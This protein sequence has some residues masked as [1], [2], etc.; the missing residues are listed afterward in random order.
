MKT[1][2]ILLQS[3]SLSSSIIDGVETYTINLIDESLQT[4]SIDGS[5]IKWL[6]GYEHPSTGISS[7]EGLLLEI[8]PSDISDILDNNGNCF[9]EAIV[10][11]IITIPIEDTKEVDTTPINNPEEAIAKDTTTVTKQ[12]N[13]RYLD[14]YCI[15]HK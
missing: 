9:V 14:G 11:N 12:L 10:E 6:L 13:I 3:A 15:I 5:K 8:T 7:E 4:G 1:N 2:D